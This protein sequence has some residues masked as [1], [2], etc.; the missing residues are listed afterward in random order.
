MD[1]RK[2]GCP[3]NPDKFKLNRAG[4]TSCAVERCVLA[5]SRS[6]TCERWSVRTQIPIWYIPRP[7]SKDIGT[8]LRPKYIP[9]SYMDPLAKRD[10]SIQHPSEATVKCREQP[11]GRGE[12][13]AFPL[14][15]V[16]VL[17]S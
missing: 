12:G 9:Y 13:F 10:P 6:L 1:H 15:L 14:Q 16:H 17:L 3:K 2:T 8:T 11:P 4:N 7:K 5:A